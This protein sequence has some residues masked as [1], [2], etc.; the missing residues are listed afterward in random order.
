M[1]NLL[2]AALF[3][4]LPFSAS[5]QDPEEQPIITIHSSAYTEVGESNQFSFLLSTTEEAVFDVDL[6]AGRNEVTFTRMEVDSS[7]GAYQGTWVPVRA[8]ANGM[9]K[10]YGDASLVDALILDGGYVTDIDMAQCTNLIILSLEHNA[11]RQLDLTPF[12]KLQAIYLTDNPFTA[13][14]PLI[15]GAPKPDLQIL[16]VDIID[17]IDPNL[18]ISDYPSLVT[19]DAYHT[20]GLNRIDPTGCPMLRS[21]SLEMTAVDRVDVSKNPRLSSL[22]VSESR[23]T[24]LDLSANPELVYLMADH[25][26]GTINTDIKL[27]HIDLSHNP[28]LFFLSITHNNL[29]DIDL[30]KNPK[31]QNLALR[32]NRLTGLDL[33]ANTNL[34][35]VDVMLNDMDYA[36]LPAP[37]STWGEYYYNQNAMPVDRV[38]GVGQVLDMSRRVLRDGATTTAKVMRKPLTGDAVEL[39]NSLYTFEDG[40]ITFNQA[41]SDSVYV[42]YSNTMF[43]D[44][45][46]TTSLFRVKDPDEVGLPSK[47]LSIS[48]DAST[49]TL[50][51]NLGVAGASQAVPKDLILDFGSDVQTT[52]TTRSAAIDDLSKV[53]VA[54][55]D[56]FS[57]KVNI[58]TP[59]GNLL[60]A[61]AV[62]GVTL[63]DVELQA[64]TALQQLS[65]TNAGLYSIDLRYNRN[66]THLDLSGNQLS[67]LSLNGIY[68]DF[69][70]NMLHTLKA[71]DNRLTA[72]DFRSGT[73]VNVLDMSGNKFTTFP[74]TAFEN[75]SS[76]DLS[77]NELA[78]E[79]SLTYQVNSTDINVSGNPITALKVDKFTALQSFDVS[80]TR[81]TL[82]TL[83]L[84]SS[85]PA[86]V[87]YAYAPQAIIPLQE[88]APAVNLTSQNRVVDGVGTTFVWK[89]T[90]GTV[91]VQGVDID[92]KDGG[93]RFLNAD[94]G[95]IYCEMTN[96]AFPGLTLRTSEITAADAP[97]TLVASFT[98]PANSTGELILRGSNDS[99]IYVDWRGDG[100]EYVEYPYTASGISNH[101]VTTVA[102]A[103]ARLYTYGDPADITVFSVY[104]VPMTEADFSPLTG[105]TSLAVGGAG[106]TAGK[107]TLPDARLSELNL[108]DNALT[109]YPYATK[110]PVLQMLNLSGNELTGF[111]ASIVPS[112]MFLYLSNNKLTS[113]KFNNP[114]LIDLHLTGNLLESVDLNGLGGI[115]QVFLNANHLSD[116]DL[117]PVKATLK[118][119]NIVSNRFTFATLPRADEAPA[120]MFYGLQAPIDAECSGGKVDLSS[121]AM[122]DGTAT[123]YQWYLGEATLDSETGEYIGEA[124]IEG[125]EYTV[126]NGITSFHSTFNEKVMCVMS[127]E[128]YPN[129]LLTTERLTVDRS[130]I[131]EIEA[132]TPAAGSGCYDLTGRRVVNPSRGGIYIINGRKTLIR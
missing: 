106:L 10:I 62:D 23:V 38:L 71:A 6:G 4:L 19:F 11:L 58:W 103:T 53:T 112:V 61:F 99:A 132:G 115:Q 57:G 5:A 65:I 18:N 42:Q 101:A 69:E 114:S 36:T 90:D 74:T 109:S 3:C 70:K 97:T 56:R 50:T 119:L 16:E 80:N 123:S 107:L 87:D 98:T 49:R 45:D 73:S 64:A 122:V 86:G 95:K 111:D 91:L 83:P 131:D 110:Y 118:A 7:T 127:N 59:E 77:D 76:L 14:T 102:G 24:E 75:L 66:L 124:L 54:L 28:E 120:N 121:Q 125:D 35:S 92:C 79:L 68:G 20:T 130:G 22:N 47:T 85:L 55:P 30:S 117:T 84:P 126:E 96:P 113:V 43:A 93:T 31:L 51:M 82:E 9:I 128:A 33:T 17:H 94:L 1:K 34:Y 81:L 25:A 37:Q 44:Y 21:L 41:V 32:G 60:T 40:K 26:S 129:L 29:T 2:K 52:V 89:K 12:T 100:T 46:L 88:Q 13:A 116:I 108:S 104:S 63:Y 67:T 27:D 39:D 15:V 48:A 72:L 78:G 8:D 105:L